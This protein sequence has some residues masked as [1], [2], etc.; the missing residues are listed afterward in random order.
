MFTIIEMKQLEKKPRDQKNAYNDTM[1]IK[2]KRNK[3]E[4]Q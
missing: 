3:L 1:T 2:D 4:D